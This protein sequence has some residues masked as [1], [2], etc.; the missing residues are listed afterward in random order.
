LYGLNIAGDFFDSIEN[1]LRKEVS[2]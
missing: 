1:R 2:E